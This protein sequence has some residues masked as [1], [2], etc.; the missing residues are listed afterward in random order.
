MDCL[1]GH[2][3][4]WELK[5]PVISV[6]GE[7]KISVKKRILDPIFKKIPNEK[8]SLTLHVFF[9]IRNLVRGLGLKVS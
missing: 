3:F 8:H 2:S 9:L 6:E 4:G 5:F 7:P 1:G